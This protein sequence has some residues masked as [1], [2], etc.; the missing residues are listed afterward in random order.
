MRATSPEPCSKADQLGVV[1][2]TGHQCPNRL[3][4][5]PCRE[6]RIGSHDTGWPAVLPQVCGCTC[7]MAW[8][9]MVRKDAGVEG[10]DVSV[11]VQLTQPEL[12]AAYV[13]FSNLT[14]QW[15]AITLG[16][17]VSIHD[18][19]EPSSVRMP[20]AAD[21]WRRRGRSTSILDG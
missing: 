10:V 13:A 7:R 5:A 16:K 9:V 17:K 21:R 4:A 18:R 8:A 14:I 15:Y 19:E 2:C 6:D 20:L 1:C 12:F 3:R 11:G